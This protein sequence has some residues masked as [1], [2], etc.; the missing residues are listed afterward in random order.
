MDPKDVFSRSVGSF[1][2]PGCSILY[3]QPPSSHQRPI[4][5]KK[6]RQWK[7]RSM[8]AARHAPEGSRRG[9]PRYLDPHKQKTDRI[10]RPL[11]SRWERV[12]P[13]FHNRPPT[14]WHCPAKPR[15]RWRIGTAAGLNLK[16]YTLLV[17]L[18]ENTRVDGKIRR[19]ISPTWARSRD[20]CCRRFSRGS[21]SNA[22]TRRASISP[23]GSRR[24]YR[25]ASSFGIS[26]AKDW[27]RWPIA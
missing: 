14:E 2:V 7:K 18:V 20:I 5:F 4:R 1:E 16:P 9:K 22:P 15:C 8:A 25:R 24:R 10:G 11:R 21:K 12:G 6:V 13:G 19:S 17:S 23:N 26:C 3:S 27:R